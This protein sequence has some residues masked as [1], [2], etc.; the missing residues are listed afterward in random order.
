MAWDGEHQEAT[1]VTWAVQG[2]EMLAQTCGTR[3]WSCKKQWNRA[4]GKGTVHAKVQSLEQGSP[5][6]V[7]TEGQLIW[8]VDSKWVQ[9]CWGSRSCS[10]L[11]ST[12][13]SLLGPRIC[14]FCFGF[15]LLLSFS[16]WFMSNWAWQAPLSV[17]FPRQEYWSR[18]PLPF[19]KVCGF[20]FVFVFFCTVKQLA[21]CWHHLPGDRLRSHRLRA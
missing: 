20:C 10:A 11:L 17:R 1:S 18:L 16:C 19:L 3:G 9:G 15:F 4:P 8:K 2:S 21:Q 5:V 12:Y 7:T 6:L 14:G 13:I